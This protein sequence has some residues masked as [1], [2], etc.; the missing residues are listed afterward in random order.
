[1]EKAE[2]IQRNCRKLVT[3]VAPPVCLPTTKTSLIFLLLVPE[4]IFPC[5]KRIS[6]EMKNRKFRLFIFYVL[7][8]GRGENAQKDLFIPFPILSCVSFCT[9]SYR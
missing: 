1:M 7:S 5:E 4:I 6:V 3:V 2:Q 8:V 9:C